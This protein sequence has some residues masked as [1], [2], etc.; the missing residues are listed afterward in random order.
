MSA[1]KELLDDIDFGIVNDEALE[2]EEN[3]ELFTE[4]VSKWQELLDDI[5]AD[6]F[7]SGKT[8]ESIDGSKEW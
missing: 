8:E 5:Q 4:Y 6:K 2:E 3:V 1:F 7:A